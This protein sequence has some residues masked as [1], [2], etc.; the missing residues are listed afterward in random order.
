M[1]VKEYFL[2]FF[3]LF[4]YVSSLVSNCGQERSRFLICVSP[5]LEEECHASM[6]HDNTDLG[7]F[8]VHAQHVEE[9]RRIKRGREGNKSSPSN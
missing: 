1:S 7:R 8:M 5:Y 6:L 2:M 3:K 4:K 9:S